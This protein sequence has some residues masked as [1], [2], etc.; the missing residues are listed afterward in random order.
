M[1]E[2]NSGAKQ[3]VMRS[4]VQVGQRYHQVGLPTFV[5]QVA[6]IYRDAQ[7][8]EHATLTNEARRRDRKTLSTAALQDRSRF[9]L[10]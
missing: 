4:K 3:R 1:K 8:L 9:R 5:W 10:I 2:T 6:S 7:G